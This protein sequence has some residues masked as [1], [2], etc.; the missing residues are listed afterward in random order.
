MP[1]K[2]IFAGTPVFAEMSLKRIVESQHRVVAVYTQPDKP[3]GRGQ[4]I[5]FNPVKTFA[6]AQGIPVYQPK[7]FREL[8]ALDALYALEADIMV[9][10]AYG[11]ILPEAVLKFPRLGCINIH[12]SLLPRW[13][14]ASPIQQSILSGDE[15][16]GITIMQMDKGLDTGDMLM[17]RALAITPEDTSETLHD[18]LALLGAE[19]IVP[20]LDALLLGVLTPEPQNDVLATY[21]P[22][23]E[24]EA[25][26][27]DWHLPAVN[28]ERMIRAYQPWP[29]AF[30]HLNDTVIK[31]YQARVVPE[32]VHV[33]A[34]TIFRQTKESLVIATGEGCLEIFSMQLPNKKV[35][36]VSDLLHSKAAFFKVG[37]VFK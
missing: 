22:K 36:N 28:L 9:V 23:I 29:V 25:A 3:Q 7:N 30:T 17:R 16:T 18:K 11:L 19:M 32:S 14:G 15:E 12:A 2:V 26:Q 37:Q 24:K 5:S 10:A 20:V 6:S 8:G 4:K 27:I 21:A 13:R 35:L 34:G 1:L 31:V 33:P